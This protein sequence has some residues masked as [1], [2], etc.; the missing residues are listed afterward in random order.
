MR[1][2]IFYKE[3][4]KTVHVDSVNKNSTPIFA[5]RDGKLKG[6]VVRD[7]KGWV[8]KLGGAFSSNGFHDT[9]K[10]CLVSSLKYGYTY[11][12]EGD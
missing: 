9:L 11:H 5:K 8:L 10:E 12:V 3:D 1:E 4:A 6:M 7:D 2:I